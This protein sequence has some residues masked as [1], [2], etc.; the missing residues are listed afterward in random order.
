[1]KILQ[2]STRLRSGGAA[3]V[4]RSLDARFRAEGHETAFVY[5]YGRRGRPEPLI[6][7]S[8]VGVTP[9]LQ[10]AASLLTSRLWGG[11]I[12][13]PGQLRRLTA[14]FVQADLIQLHIVHSHLASFVVLVQA[15]VASGRP[16]VWTHHDQWVLT[17]RCAIPDDCG[18]FERAGGG[19]GPCPRLS[20]YPPS[21]IDLSGGSWAK[22][23][24]MI[25][26]LNSSNPLAFVGNCDW[27]SDRLN[28][29]YPN[30]QCETIRNGADETF[31]E[32]ADS[33]HG[34][35]TAGKRVLIVAADLD[36]SQK[37]NKRLLERLLTEIPS[38]ELRLV[39]RNPPMRGDR[40]TW[41]G[42]IADRA[43]LLSEYRNAE[44]L[45]FMSTIDTVGMVVVEASLVGLPTIMASSTGSLELG[46]LLG[47]PVFSSEDEVVDAIRA[48]V[49]L[50]F[51]MDSVKRAARQ[52]F[53]GGAR[54][55]EY[56]ALY[57]GLCQ[58]R[59]GH[60]DLGSQSGPVG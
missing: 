31:L 9:Q 37:V 3:A 45:L 16:V 42:E 12:S 1:M 11:D 55:A 30:V 35:P 25:E 36:D 14:L 15:L 17:G 49:H 46:G 4:A 5:G 34:R 43:A 38:V 44:L 50:D 27:V 57:Q 51:E 58:T 10:A 2:V 47:L 26:I 28:Q 59:P 32:A 29:E 56:L 23:R 39:G 40:V 8:Q 22:K 24:Q 60:L 54:S 53:D 33:A 7:E 6:M 41:A 21:L 20:A 48:R 18:R 52:A 13:L 19:C